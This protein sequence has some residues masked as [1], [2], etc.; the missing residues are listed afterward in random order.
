MS[1]MAGTPSTK[2]VLLTSF[3]VDAVDFLTNILVA[4]I[5]G[6]AVM[7]VEAMQGLADLT[8]VFLLILGFKRS[9]RRANKRHPYGFGKEQ[10]FWAVVSAF[11]ILIITASLSFYFGY[12][13]FKHPTPVKVLW[14]AYFMLLVGMCTNGY[15]FYISSKKLLSGRPV[16]NLVRIFFESSQVG[17]RTTAV[18]DFTGFC[19]AL[20][21]F[22]AL[23]MYGITGDG[24][25]DGIGA[26][27]MAA[28]LAV[29]AVFLLA[30][31][32]SLIV[33]Q[34]A[35]PELEDK[36]THTAES[37][38]EVQKILGL[39]TML[40]GSDSVLVNI[41]V[42]LKNGLTTDQ[43]ENI[44]DTVQK[45]IQALGKKFIVHVEIEKP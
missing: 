44:V 32:R 13:E 35:P 7:L 19:A 21:G 41:E 28:T 26:M 14:L 37:V 11:I 5:T 29:L 18:L 34:S 3:A 2:R 9:H 6:S 27:V 8:S 43:V 1:I 45:N 36:I 17:P 10:Y 12:Q 15:A 24:R 22:I 40:L 42:H 16:K 38:P 31:A 4:I 33:G 23:V 39:Q 25:W 20:F 30:G